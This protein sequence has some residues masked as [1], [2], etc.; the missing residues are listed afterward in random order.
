MA[1]IEKVS[2]VFGGIKTDEPI[3]NC[4]NNGIGIENA[5]NING[6]N[7]I[8]NSSTGTNLPAKNTFW[9]KVKSVLFH[10]TN[11]SFFQMLLLEIRNS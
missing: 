9:N 4:G 6:E 11:F 3:Q 1:N 10:S 7:T 8:N 5:I 2:G